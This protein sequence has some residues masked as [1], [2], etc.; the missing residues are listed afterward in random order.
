MFQ[1]EPATYSSAYKKIKAIITRDPCPGEPALRELA[2]HELLE[3]ERVLCSDGR[4]QRHQI[5]PRPS[6][7]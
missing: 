5:P 6:H 4:Q 7:L 1:T 2:R 3:R